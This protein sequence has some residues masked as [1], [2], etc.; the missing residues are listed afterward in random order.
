MPPWLLYQVR[1]WLPRRHLVIV[2]D[3]AFAALDFLGAAKRHA[4]IITRL[5]LDAALYAPAPHRLPGQ[6]GRTR[7][8][9]ERLPALGKVLADRATAWSTLTVAY[10]YGEHDRQVEVASGTAVWY[11]SGMPPIALRWVLIRDPLQQFETQALLCTAQEATPSFILECFVQRWQVEVT[12]EEARAHL[13]VETQRQW[14][15]K[16]ILRTTPCLA[17]AIFPCDTGRAAAV[18]DRTDLPALRRLV[19]QTGGGFSD[20]IAGVR[21]ELWSH[22]YF[23]MSNKDVDMVKIPSPL[24]DRFIDS[25]CYAA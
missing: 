4:T 19:S 5:R 16:A 2:T 21:R 8:K 10:W 1:R 13:G 3:S 9:G 15:D 23:S 25:L 7:L 14:S 17:G 12:F 22:A 24:V 20:T 11:H 6:L 18:L